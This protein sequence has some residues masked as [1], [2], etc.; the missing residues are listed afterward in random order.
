MSCNNQLT[1]VHEFRT[2]NLL[3]SKPELGN[4]PGQKISFKRIRI[5]IRNRDGSI[6]DL[7]FSTSSQLHSFGLQES[8][9]MDS[10][11]LGGYVLPICLWSRNG[12]T[13]MEQKF[14]DV[15]TEVT[16]FCKKYLVDHREDIEKYDLDYSDLKKFNPLYWKTEKGKIV[17]GRGPTLYGK[18]QMSKKDQRISTIFVDEDTNREID[19]FSILNKPCSVTAA[20]KIESIFIGNKLSLQ[21]KLYEVVVKKIDT[22]IRGLLRPNAE[23][24][25]DDLCSKMTEEIQRRGGERENHLPSQK[26]EREEDEGSI[27]EFE[28]EEEEE[29]EGYDD[30]SFPLSEEE[31]LFASSFSMIPPSTSSSPPPQSYSSPPQSYSSP[32]SSDSTEYIPP[33]YSGMEQDNSVSLKKKSAPS[34][35]GTRKK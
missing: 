19:P 7:I 32:P 5:A 14:T 4:I 24:R 28:N 3:F 33:T 22:T 18:V 1:P 35:R 9:N 20:V 29:G 30:P 10:G 15:F 25:N 27:G 12:P 31:K 8:L 21:V 11:K 26:K 2:D 34:S 6:G 16:E 17:E 13:E 23:K